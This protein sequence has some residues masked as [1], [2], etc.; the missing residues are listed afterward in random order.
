MKP[1]HNSSLPKRQRRL[2]T[3]F[4]A[5]PSYFLTLCTK[6]RQPVL[7][8]D[9]VQRRVRQFV[10]GSM[11]RYQVW[12]D[13]YVLMPDHVHLIITVGG[14][15][16]LGEWVKAFKAFVRNREFYWQDSFFDHILQS[17]ESR[18]EKWEYIRQNPVRAGL[19][20]SVEEWPYADRFDPR[21]GLALT[22]M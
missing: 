15:I 5:A 8:E 1:V 16:K 7:A 20:S 14:D 17:R 6:D 9:G 12:V 3:L 13:S 19:V 18:S 4:E 21:T 10:G 2:D 22:D 11:D